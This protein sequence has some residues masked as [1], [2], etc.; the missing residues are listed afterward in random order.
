MFFR[1]VNSGQ[2]SIMATQMLTS[3]SAHVIFVFTVNQVMEGAI[4]S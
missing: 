2:P 3:Q 1:L 4:Y